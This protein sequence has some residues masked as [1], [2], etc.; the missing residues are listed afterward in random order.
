MFQLQ[1]ELQGAGDKQPQALPQGARWYKTVVCFENGRVFPSI[2]F[3]RRRSHPL[4][5]TSPFT[6]SLGLRSLAMFWIILGHTFNFVIFV[7]ASDYYFIAHVLNTWQDQVLLAANYSVD[8]FFFLSG[9][10]TAYVI[11]KKMAKSG[12]GTAGAWAT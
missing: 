8:T 6:F 5:K 7:N 1:Q 11:G 10:L 12:K 2:P 9:L 4:R 3:L